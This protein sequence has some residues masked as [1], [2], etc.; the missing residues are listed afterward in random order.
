VAYRLGLCDSHITV[1]M[2]GGSLQIKVAENLSIFMSGPV[3]KVAEGNI[4]PEMFN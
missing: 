4:F 1:H 3:T 2:P